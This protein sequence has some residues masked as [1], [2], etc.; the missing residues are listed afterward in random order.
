M[1]SHLRGFLVAITVYLRIILQLA[2]AATK[3]VRG[4]AA[5]FSSRLGRRRVQRWV[6]R[7]NPAAGPRAASRGL[8]VGTVLVPE[9]PRLSR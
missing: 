6:Q 4:A 9:E 8:G 3:G 2:L 7:F 5:A 1:S